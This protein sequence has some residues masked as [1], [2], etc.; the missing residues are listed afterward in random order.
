[1]AR[2]KPL[3]FYEGWNID[4]FSE[5]GVGLRATL[6]ATEKRR[7]EVITVAA[8]AGADGRVIFRQLLEAIDAAN[9][10]M[11][12]PEWKRWAKMRDAEV[13]HAQK[14]GRSPIRV[15]YDDPPRIGG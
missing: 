5:G 6:P 4:E 3:D 14:E 13:D 11:Q 2:T 7:Q 8:G 1:M 10:R 9:E 15:P 12:N